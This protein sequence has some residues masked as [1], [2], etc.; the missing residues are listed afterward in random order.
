MMS[1][2]QANADIEKQAGKAEEAYVATTPP[3]PDDLLKASKKELIYS[4]SSNTVL[5]LAIL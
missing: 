5:N 3:S 4:E 2:K 1:D